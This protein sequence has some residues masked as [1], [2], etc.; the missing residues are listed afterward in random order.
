MALA[1]DPAAHKEQAVEPIAV[2]YWPD[3]QPK[4]ALAPDA[5]KVPEEQLVQPDPPVMAW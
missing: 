3:A 5:E 1:D 4:Q 2:W